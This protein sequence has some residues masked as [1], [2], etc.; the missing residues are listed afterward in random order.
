MTNAP[1]LL[2]VV[3]LLLSPNSM[4]APASQYWGM[5]DKSNE[6][7]QKEIDHGSWARF[8]NLYVQEAP[9]GEGTRVAYGK[10]KPEDKKALTTYI[11][12]LTALDPR[13]FAKAE[14]KAYWINLYNALTVD[15]VLKNYPVKSITNLG[16]WYSFG[17][18]DQIVTEVVGQ[19]LTPE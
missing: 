8:L 15:L 1:A 10:V 6:Q 14:Q 13:N 18:W 17:P 9:A 2:L 7:S 16:P 12:S 5:W 19:A 11:K 3:M 4:A